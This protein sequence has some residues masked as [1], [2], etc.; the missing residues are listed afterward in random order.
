MKKNGGRG[1][2][3]LESFHYRVALETA[4]KVLRSEDPLMKLIATHETEGKGAF[5]FRDAERAVRKLQDPTLSLDF[6]NAG[7]PMTP[8]EWTRTSERIK[9]AHLEI[10]MQEHMGKCIHSLFFRCL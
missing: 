6:D 5:I 1:V 9:K 3:N 8:Q 2:I 10:L 4:T 7:R